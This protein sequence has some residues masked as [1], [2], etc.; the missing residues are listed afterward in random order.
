MTPRLT[1]QCYQLSKPEI[2]FDAME[3][4]ARN[5][6]S[7]HVQK[8]QLFR[9]RRLNHS[10]VGGGTAF[11]RVYPARAYTTLVVLVLY[12]LQLSHT[13]EQELMHTNNRKIK[14]SHP[15]YNLLSKK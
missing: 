11:R 1:E 15:T 4:C 5:Y 14:S 7:A 13:A 8:R 2:E 12:S 3:K 10:G 6:A 9:Q